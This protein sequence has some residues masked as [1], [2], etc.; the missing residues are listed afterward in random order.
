VC[1]CA[2]GW[3]GGWVGGRWCLG[4]VHALERGV[5]LVD[6][7]IGNAALEDM[8]VLLLSNSITSVC[9]QAY[10]RV[11]NIRVAKSTCSERALKREAALKE[12]QLLKRRR[13]R[14]LV[15]PK[16]SDDLW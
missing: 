3:V 4:G 12:K 14:R 5:V 2:C 16:V 6:D 7:A 8:S 10:M 15:L 13:F 1:V 9:M 11:A